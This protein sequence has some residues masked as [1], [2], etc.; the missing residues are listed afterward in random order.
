MGMINI[1]IMYLPNPRSLQV[2]IPYTVKTLHPTALE[3]INT[4]SVGA[5][6]FS[7]LLKAILGIMIFDYFLEF[8]KL[9]FPIILPM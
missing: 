3:S 1:E 7:V 8:E 6:L 4:K 2:F 9:H 5:H